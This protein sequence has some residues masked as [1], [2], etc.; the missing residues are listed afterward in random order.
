MKFLFFLV[1]S[2]SYVD[3]DTENSYSSERVLILFGNFASV[4]SLYKEQLHYLSCI[5]SCVE[6]FASDFRTDFVL[7]FKWNS[8]EL[9]NPVEKDTF[10]DC[11]YSLSKFILH[12]HDHT[13][14][15]KRSSS[16]RISV[17]DYFCPSLIHLDVDEVYL[18]FRIHESGVS[19]NARARKNDLYVCQLGLI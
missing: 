13:Q 12:D 1:R 9:N 8:S 16:T 7:S 6:F 10:C 3:R 14:R 11:S 2:I 5:Q 18:T 19:V 17:Q 4:F 15:S